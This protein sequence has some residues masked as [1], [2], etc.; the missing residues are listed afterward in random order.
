MV[1]CHLSC[2]ECG[3]TAECFLWLCPRTSLRRMNVFP[4]G[5]RLFVHYLGKWGK[6]ECQV[7]G[8][9]T[10][11]FLL[12]LIGE[13]N[14]VVDVCSRSLSMD[15]FSIR[16]VRNTKGGARS[17]PFPKADSLVTGPSIL[18]SAA[19]GDPHSFLY[20]LIPSLFENLLCTRHWVYKDEEDR[21]LSHSP[22]IVRKCGGVKKGTIQ[23]FWNLYG[24]L[25]CGLF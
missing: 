2:I 25:T 4:W 13:E 5:K 19:T 22:Q 17:F 20:S 11:V 8:I 10:K 1:K 14:I 9:L 23:R 3:I 16:H 12:C 18:P 24:V 7:G 15:S 21:E 6:N